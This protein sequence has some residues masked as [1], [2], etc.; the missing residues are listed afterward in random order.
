MDPPGLFPPIAEIGFSAPFRWLRQGARDMLARAQESFF[1]G[2]CFAAMGLAV[3]KVFEHAYQYSS[4]M[5]SGFMLL[6]PFLAIGLYEISRQQTRNE[7]RPF[8]ETLT[9]WRRNAGNIG[10]F[11][12]V[13]MVIFLVWAR[14]SLVVFALFYTDEMP[15]LSGF[16]LQITDPKN[17]EFILV[18]TCV[19]L[20]FALFVFAVSIVS[21]P[22]MLDRNQDAITAMLS[23]A[24]AL[25]HNP[26]PCLLWAFLIAAL[27]IL[28]FATF[29]IGLIVAMPLVGHATWHA[30][31][32]LV[33]PAPA[34]PGQG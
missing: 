5:T 2:F 25:A 28:G 19:G 6:G 20:F 18:Y 13:L 11:S 26:G 27:T 12:L 32:D 34:T 33:S 7:R 31:R 21:I 29:H 22:M 10:I 23:S 8:S 15:S 9:V 4:A 17:L 14:A 1:F 16:L 24:M 3:T 30:Y